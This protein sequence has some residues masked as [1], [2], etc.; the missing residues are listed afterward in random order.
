[1]RRLLFFAAALLATLTLRANGDPVAKRSALTLARTP[2]AVHV[3]E[4]G[5]NIINLSTT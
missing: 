1:M 5:L 4:V 2:V 3:P